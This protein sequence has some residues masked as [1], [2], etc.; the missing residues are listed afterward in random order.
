MS[1]IKEANFPRAKRQIIMNVVL[2]FLV[3]S[4]TLAQRVINGFH[5]IEITYFVQHDKNKSTN[6][7]L[8]LWYAPICF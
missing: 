4:D 6:F 7:G 1:K 5:T 8:M 3:L 2:F